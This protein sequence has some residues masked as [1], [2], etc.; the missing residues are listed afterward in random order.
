MLSHHLTK[1]LEGRA[2]ACVNKNLYL[3]PFLSICWFLHGVHVMP[4]KIV[5]GQGDSEGVT[6]SLWGGGMEVCCSWGFSLLSVT[7]VA[8]G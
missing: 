7:V 6:S 3:L 8:M 1:R 2:N 4:Q 5:V